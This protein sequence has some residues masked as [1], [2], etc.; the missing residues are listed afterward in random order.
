MSSH[1]QLPDSAAAANG[2]PPYDVCT[3]G[4]L[5]VDQLAFV[6][7]IHRKFLLS[8]ARRLSVCLETPV[9]TSLTGIDQMQFPDFIDSCDV[10]ACLVEV[11]AEP[12]AGRAI[13]ELS[14]GLVHRMLSILIGVPDN[15]PLPERGIT[16]I[17]TH[18]LRECLDAIVLELR[19]TWAS[20]R[21]DFEPLPI[22]PGDRPA[23]EGAA[24]ILTSSVGVAGAQEAMRLA[25]PALLVRLAVRLG[26]N[27]M[28]PAIAP[29]RATAKPLLLDAMR[30]ASVRVE[31][32]LGGSSL[33]L[34]DLSALEPGQVLML[35][36]PANCA[37]ECL[38]NGVSKFRGEMVSNGRTQGLQIGAPID[39]A[40]PR[41]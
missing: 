13:L 34:R 20:Y 6:E 1:S 9:T 8:L 41:D 37:V 40:S 17:E 35:G 5:P 19:E 36:S 22:A 14:P 30:S 25:L 38:I 10:D 24:L 32:V 2:A 11:T 26:A 15:T 21:I 31:A 29:S 18:I 4:V 12:G 33:R 39:R 7:I 28:A 27:D 3:P 23:M 16:G